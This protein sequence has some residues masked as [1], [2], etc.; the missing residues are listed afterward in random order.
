MPSCPI[1]PNA[2]IA[3]PCEKT[4]CYNNI[5]GLDFRCLSLHCTIYNKSE[6]EILNTLY[7]KPYHM[8]VALAIKAMRVAY[9]IKGLKQKPAREMGDLETIWHDRI[10]EAGPLNPHVHW[11][12]MI[13]KNKDYLL[14]QRMAMVLNTMEVHEYPLR[15]ILES[16]EETFYRLDLAALALQDEDLAAVKTLMGVRR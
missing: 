4:T 11:T 3:G 5:S 10:A 14:I 15:D 13:V 2:N 9:A 7:G 6:P 8:M 12:E 1:N 16:Y